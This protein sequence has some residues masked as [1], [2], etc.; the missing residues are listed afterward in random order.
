KDIDKLPV[1]HV[2]KIIEVYRARYNFHSANGH[3]MIFNNVGELAGASIHHPHSQLVV[4][5]KQI[6]V[7]SLSLE[8]DLNIV[9][10][11]RGFVVFCPEF[12]QWPFETWIAPKIGGGVFGAIKDEA[13]EDLAK[14]LQNTLRRLI[15]H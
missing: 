9:D 4:V 15:T 13:I 2:S 12:S 6:N 10:D 5:P 14:T 7:D 11:N 1:E 8:P 3:V